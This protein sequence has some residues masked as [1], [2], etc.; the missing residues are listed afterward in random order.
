MAC[1]SGLWLSW[2]RSLLTVGYAPNPSPAMSPPGPWRTPS[3]QQVG[4][5]H[6]AF[7]VIPSPWASMCYAILDSSQK[8]SKLNYPGVIGADLACLAQW[9][10]CSLFLLT[11]RAELFFILV[12]RDDYLISIW[13]YRLGPFWFALCTHRSFLACPASA[14]SSSMF[15]CWIE[16]DS[17]SECRW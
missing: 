8:I 7:W 1:V 14:T 17:G 13:F 3:A 16:Q 12:R 10:P 15:N 6:R 9:M 2:R 4:W 11:V 5:R